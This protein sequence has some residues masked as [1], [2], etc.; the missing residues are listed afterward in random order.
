MGT[1]NPGRGP[2]VISQ[3][4]DNV[5]WARVVVVEVVRTGHILDLF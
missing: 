5:A 3:V 4:G 2:L 1:E